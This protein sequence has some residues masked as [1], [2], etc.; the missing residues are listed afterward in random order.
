MQSPNRT[1]HISK[2]ANA[3][4]K[5]CLV[6][7]RMQSS[8]SQELAE[9][10]NRL[11]KCLR[12]IDDLIQDSDN[13]KAKLKIVE[14]ENA[15]LSDKV[16]VSEKS[17]SERQLKDLVNSRTHH[18]KKSSDGSRDTNH[19]SEEKLTESKLTDTLKE[20]NRLKGKIEELELDKR[21]LTNLKDEAVKSQ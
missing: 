13:V 6:F 8:L 20:N 10:E 14:Q 1:E 12:L 9:K 16:K 18:V 11:S 4:C 19:K 21:I 2:I 17:K 15:R 3:G 7:I 5:E